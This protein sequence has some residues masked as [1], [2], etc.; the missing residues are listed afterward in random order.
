MTT[1]KGVRK[2]TDLLDYY[3]NIW[4]SKSHVLEHLT[5]T[6]PNKENSKWTY[7]KYNEFKM[8]KRI[9]DWDTKLTHTEFNKRFEVQTND[10]NLRLGEVISQEVKP[11]DF[12]SSKLNIHNSYPETGKSDKSGK[13]FERISDYITR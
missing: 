13:N 7:I 10:R 11:I 4:S 6:T 2:F 8:I 12:Y 3:C 1:Q 9:M 5:N